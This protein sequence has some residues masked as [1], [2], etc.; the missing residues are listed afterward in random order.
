MSS[1]EK[2]PLSSELDFQSLVTL[3]TLLLSEVPFSSLD[4]CLVSRLFFLLVVPPVTPLN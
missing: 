3:P 2:L 1:G 4:S